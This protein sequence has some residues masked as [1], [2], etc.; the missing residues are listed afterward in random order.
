MPLLFTS[1]ASAGSSAVGGASCAPTDVW[2]ASDIRKQF[3]NN[4]DPA[5]R[6]GEARRHNESLCLLAEK[7]NIL[8]VP[9]TTENIAIV[10]KLANDASKNKHPYDSNVAN[11][12]SASDGGRK[13]SDK[14]CDEKLLCALRYDIDVKLSSR[15]LGHFEK[16][17]EFCADS[18]VRRDSVSPAPRVPSHPPPSLPSSHD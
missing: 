18:E 16:A 2:L 3:T 11:D 13:I 5:H 8:G 14:S 12:H 17:R 6:V 7:L 4:S 9:K 1:G 15:E 10:L